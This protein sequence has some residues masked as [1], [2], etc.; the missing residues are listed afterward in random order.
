MNIK[1]KINVL[2]D[3]KKDVSEIIGYSSINDNL[4]YLPN[5]KWNI[6][7][8]YLRILFDE[9]D[10][11]EYIISS[12]SAKGEKFF[13]GEKDGLVFVMGYLEDNFTEDTEVYILSKENEVDSSFLENL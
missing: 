8:E 4:D 13:K 12:Y 11:N 9:T 7:G 5:E 1:E 6:D 2:Q 3:L 10:Y